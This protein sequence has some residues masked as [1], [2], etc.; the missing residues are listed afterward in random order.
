MNSLACLRCLCLP[1]EA[2]RA[3]CKKLQTSRRTQKDCD[4][5]ES[6][7]REDPGSQSMFQALKLRRCCK[8]AVECAP[9][10]HGAL[11]YPSEVVSFG[12]EPDRLCQKFTERLSK[13]S[14]SQRPQSLL[15]LAHWYFCKV[16][17]SF[18]K[19][20]SHRGRGRR[21]CSHHRLTSTDDR[22]LVKPSS[23]LGQPVNNT[24]ECCSGPGPASNFSSR[25]A[26]AQEV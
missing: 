9:V 7:L 19:V 1:S 20:V 23:K 26:P 17:P 22:N 14:C 16:A 10:E 15:H 4:S 18:L 21:L 11:Q 13:R 2:A 12:L 3:S 8:P 6:E 24:Q 5:Q 25:W